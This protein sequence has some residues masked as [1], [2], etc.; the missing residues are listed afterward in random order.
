[1]KKIRIFKG[2]KGIEAYLGWVL[3][4]GFSV[5]ISVF[6]YSWINSQVETSVTNIE[7]RADTSACDEAGL[8]LKTICQNTQTLN[9]NI[10]NIRLLTISGM[11]FRFFDLYDNQDSR[12]INVTIRP[13]DTESLE[14]IKQGTL[15]Q[16][17][18]IPIIREGN[19]IITCR[20]SMITSENIKI[21]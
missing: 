8:T 9:M 6:M 10:T 20:K 12:S 17:E 16:V 19:N 5:V 21:C 13:S 15:K 3:L 2:K 11:N 7:N 18:I 4:I 1:M 14:V